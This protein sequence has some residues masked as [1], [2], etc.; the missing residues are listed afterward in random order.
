MSMT[1]EKNERKP[2]VHRCGMCR[3]CEPNS[4]L[5]F[6]RSHCINPEAIKNWPQQRLDGIAPERMKVRLKDTCRFW[7]TRRE[8]TH[9]T[10]LRSRTSSICPKLK[11]AVRIAPGT[12]ISPSPCH[13]SKDKECEFLGSPIF[14]NAKERE[15]SIKCFFSEEG[16]HDSEPKI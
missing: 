12:T 7:A 10:W 1:E 9:F 8:R 5:A 13:V 4:G 14:V 15:V 3:S 2:R 11:V 6:A 16:Q